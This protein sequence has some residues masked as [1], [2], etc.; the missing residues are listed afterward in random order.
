MYVHPYIRFCRRPQKQP[1]VKIITAPEALDQRIR[2]LLLQRIFSATVRYLMYLHDKT[3][4]ILPGLP[5]TT[6]D[7]PVNTSREQRVRM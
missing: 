1:Y 2:V 7:A 5:G 3:D 4:G 6:K